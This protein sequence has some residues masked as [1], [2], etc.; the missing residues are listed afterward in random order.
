M[1][2]YLQATKSQ[3]QRCLKV[4]IHKLEDKSKKC[5]FI[6]YSEESKTYRLF[7]LEKDIVTNVDIIFDENNI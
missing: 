6:G 5:L 1:Q 7:D 4:T 2:K 3:Q